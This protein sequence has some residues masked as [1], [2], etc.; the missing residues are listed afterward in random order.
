LFLNLYPRETVI[1]SVLEQPDFSYAGR[2]IVVAL[3]GISSYLKIVTMSETDSYR[4]ERLSQANIADL[5][6]IYRAAFGK[7]QTTEYFQKKNNTQCFGAT[8]VG[9]IAYSP[10]GEPAAF[11]GAYSCVIE[12]KGQRY[13]AAQTGDA[14][15]HPS[16][17]RKGLFKALSN[18]TFEAA[19][20]EGISFLFNFPNK[21]A[22]SYPLLL[23]QQWISTGGWQSYVIRVRG[24][25]IQ[26][27]RKLVPIGNNAYYAYCRLV[28]KF[29]TTS[30]TAFR[31]SVIDED[32]G[33]I[34]RSV[35]YLEY[36]TYARNFCLKIKNTIVWLSIRGNTLLVGDMERCALATFHSIIRR[37]KILALTLGLG[38]VEFKCSAG[39]YMEKLFDTVK[40]W[41]ADNTNTAILCWNLDESFP[42]NAIKFT[43]A[44]Y[45]TF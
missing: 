3:R 37:L 9:Y 17:Q 41:K 39:V 13:L 14:M 21:T 7:E 10:K 1:Q 30:R 6:I 19:K 38:Y 20:Q 34:E 26:S 2:K 40:S 31:N 15:T 22:D 25:S 4:F 27:V 8:N 29:F 12:Y 33:G 36:K 45:D 5:T 44:D 16:H 28:L 32:T 23:K 18:L 43:I 42:V 35:D 11:Y 24:L